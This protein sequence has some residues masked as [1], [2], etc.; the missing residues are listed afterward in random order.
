[1]ELLLTQFLVVVLDDHDELGIA[2]TATSYDNDGD[3]QGRRN[4]KVAIA[5]LVVARPSRSLETSTV[6]EDSTKICFSE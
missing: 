4:R 5:P 1:M 3:G 2:E 6:F